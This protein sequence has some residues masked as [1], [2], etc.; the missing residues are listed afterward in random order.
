[1]TDP[2]SPSCPPILDVVKTRA[3]T[4]GGGTSILE[5]VQTLAREEGLAG[6]TRGIEPTLLG[7]L[8]Y[9]VT[10]YPGYEFFK[11][12]LNSA[13]EDR[14]GLEQGRCVFGWEGPGGGRKRSAI[15]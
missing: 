8:F 13:G 14:S 1:M 3:Q 11:R 15:L 12:A 5:G 6:L 9:G 4:S 2:P 10:V 7:Y